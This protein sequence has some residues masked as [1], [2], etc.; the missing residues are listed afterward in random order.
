MGAQGEGWEWEADPR[1][2]QS[3]VNSY[4]N[5]Y[6]HP[7]VTPGKVGSIKE[8]GFDRPIKNPETYFLRIRILKR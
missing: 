8:P 5:E 3:I 2:A 4:D 6:L 1:L 7:Y